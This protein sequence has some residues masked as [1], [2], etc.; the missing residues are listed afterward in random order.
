[1]S[2]KKAETPSN[3]PQGGDF[4]SFDDKSEFQNAEGFYF[5]HR[6]HGTDE[7]FFAKLNKLRKSV[8][9]VY[10]VFEKKP[11][12]LGVF[13]LKKINAVLMWH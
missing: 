2:K 4:Y 13:A 6:I 5:E 12:R 8:S 9:F 3:S 7:T 11:L 1:M 10:S